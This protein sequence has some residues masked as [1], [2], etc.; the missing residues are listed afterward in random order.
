[1]LLYL[2]NFYNK[3]LKIRNKYLQI[4]LSILKN[5]VRKKNYKMLTFDLK[6]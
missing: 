3:Q 4:S 2:Y 6:Y 5:A 1:M